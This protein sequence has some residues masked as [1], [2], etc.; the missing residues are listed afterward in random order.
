MMIAQIEIEICHIFGRSGWKRIPPSIKK[1]QKKTK[2]LHLWAQ[3]QNLVKENN[4]FPILKKK[5][6]L[7]NPLKNTLWTLHVGLNRCTQLI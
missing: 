5:K 3:L 6:S 7:L 1:K 2:Q 4:N